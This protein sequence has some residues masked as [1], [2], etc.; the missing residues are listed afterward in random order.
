MAEDK[1]SFILY[2]DYLS[3]VQKLPDKEAGELFKHILMYVNDLNPTTDNFVIDIAFEPIKLQMKRDLVKWQEKRVVKSEAGRLGGIKS[4][5][6][7]RKQNEANEANALNL[8]QNEANEAVNFTVTVTDNVIVNDINKLTDILI[9]SESI[10]NDSEIINGLAMRH[11]ITP[12]ITL[13]YVDRFY[14]MIKSTGEN[15]YI[16][17]EY[18][19]YLGNWI[20]TELKKEYSANKNHQHND[21]NPASKL[22]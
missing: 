11:S 16:D 17:R 6:A 3:V 15:K 4:G 5:E 8:K 21:Y 20:G 10:K 14:L 18:K 22:F 7:R 9:I 12:I 13:K 1:K 19:K 2:A